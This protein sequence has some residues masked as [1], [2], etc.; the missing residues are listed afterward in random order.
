LAA[1]NAELADNVGVDMDFL[2]HG[3]EL[4]RGCML[5]VRF[6]AFVFGSE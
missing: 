3:D 4:E 5:A 2:D 1:G 6:C